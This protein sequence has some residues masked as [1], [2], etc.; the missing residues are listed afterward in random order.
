MQAVLLCLLA[1][2][3][4]IANSQ[5]ESKRVIVGTVVAPSGFIDKGRSDPTARIE[6]T[7]G[8]RQERLDKLQKIFQAVSDPKSPDYGHFLSAE[9]VE[10]LTEPAQGD[11]QKV[12]TWLMEAGVDKSDVQMNGDSI[13]VKSTVQAAERLFD[14]TMHRFVNAESPEL[15]ADVILG[16]WSLPASLGPSEGHSERLVQLLTGITQFPRECARLR[17]PIVAGERDSQGATFAEK[18]DKSEPIQR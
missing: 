8:L 9:Q 11:Q 14:A 4:V 12:L 6:F 18:S 2:S 10:W 7:L 15:Q 16:D 13:H 5:P 1:M 17:H 3:S